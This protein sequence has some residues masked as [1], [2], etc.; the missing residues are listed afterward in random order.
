M[1]L[2]LFWKL[3][4]AFFA[5][6]IAVLLPVDYYAEH[7]LRRDYE[8]TGFDQ[9]AAIAHIALA[10]PPQSS[11]LSV[12]QPADA[13]ALREWVA[14]MAASGAR[15]TVITA[16]GLVL[17]DSESDPRTMENHA[18]RPEIREAFAKGEGESIRHSVTINR[19][20]LYYAVRFSVPGG[21]PVVLRFAL[22]LQTVDEEMG[23]FR[24]RLWFASLMMLLVTGTASL[25][26]SRFFSRRV[27]RLRMFSRRVAEG[28]FRPID[29]D[30]SGDALEALAVSLNDTAARLDRTIRT[31]TEER[32]LSA[33]ILGSMVEG[34]AVVNARERLLFANPGFAEILEL[35]APP[36]PGSA[37]VEVVRQTELIE[38]VREVL[39]G[40]PRV[41][42]E[43]VTG[44]LRQRFFAVTVASVRAA[45]ASGAVVVLHDITDL[46]KLE[47]VRRDFVANVSH[48][49]KTPLTAIQGFAE[50]LL[51]GAMDD[52]QN[53]LRFLEIILDHS[54][55]LARLTDDLLKLS[56][57][58]AERLE[59]EIRRLSVSQFV[60]SCIETTQR[61]A[62][63]KD[64][65]I[66][67]NV[68]EKLPD[69]A[70][71]RRLLAEVL[72]NLLDNAI[73]YTPSGGQIMVSASA[74]GNEV[75]FTVSDTG[76]GIPR[77]DQ[78]RIFERFYRVDVAR[79]R[80]VGG[81]GLGLS[82]AKHL[83][84]AHGGRIWVE[85][86]VGQG[87]QFHFT[88]PVFD[89]ERASSRAER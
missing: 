86:E 63:E 61:S 34:V 31:L 85:S 69:I 38:A 7:A 53:R 10:N 22:P 4:F 76:I 50:T 5:L 71:D 12:T 42:T 3:G 43:I 14:K 65:R 18:G 28:D 26:V 20:L 80:E 75:T 8:R 67:V 64:L 87:S 74:N 21:S 83:V 52:R 19:D 62:A 73:Q 27:E 70:A 45:E 49:F 33:A 37:L 25:L 57:M 44:T 32:N 88:V 84:E 11:S 23:E 51:A 56:K 66:S 24:R 41:E 17:A 9:L 36:Q 1:R 82:I 46:R 30:R 6:L 58:D 79:S 40:A 55:R 77:A 89:S 72:Q 68:G 59:L 2:N 15:V 54:R 39:K 78:P 48:E 81:T 16:D 35:D 60:E 29:A 13:T 47:R